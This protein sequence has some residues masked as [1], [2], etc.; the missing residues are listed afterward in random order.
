MDLLITKWNMLFFVN[1]FIHLFIY[2]CLGLS[3]IILATG[4]CLL[5]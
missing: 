2:F 1:R 5:P 3:E 4:V